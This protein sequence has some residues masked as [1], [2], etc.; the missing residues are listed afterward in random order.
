M[1]T[2]K[3]KMTSGHGTEYAYLDGLTYEEAL[4]ICEDNYWIVDKGFIWDLYIE[5]E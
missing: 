3:I 2:Y 4:Q 5:E 1:K